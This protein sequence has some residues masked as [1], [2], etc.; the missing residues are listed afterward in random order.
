M[1]LW[2][3]DGERP[4]PPAGQ[5]GPAAAPPAAGG[6]PGLSADQP[7]LSPEQEAQARAMAKE[8]ADA[9]ARLLETDVST[10]LANHAMGIYELAAIHLTADEPDLDEA[11]LAVDA[12]AALV[13][14]LS[15]RLGEAE[16]T[17]TDALHQLRMVFVQ[18]HAGEAPV[19]G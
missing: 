6:D 9:R 3:P 8:L 11:R 1:S 13:E 5:P 4:V 18:R 12:L 19:S 17:L 7:E 10:V 16:S 2:T 15:G 14:G